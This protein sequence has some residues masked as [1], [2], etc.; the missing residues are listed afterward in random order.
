MAVL[1]AVFAGC[2][3]AADI[4]LVGVIGDKAAVLS[5]D[6]GAPKTIRVGRSFSGISVLAVEG[7]RAT[8]LIDGK[9][10][11]LVRGQHAASGGGVTSDRQRVTLVADARGHF[12]TD[13]A[14][15]GGSMRFLVDTGATAIAIPAADALRL[16]ID[17][18]KGGRVTIS[19]ANGQAQ[20]YLVKF[21]TVRVG[22]IE[23]AN[24][25]GMVVERGLSIALL[26]MSFLNR[27]EMQRDSH[28][29]TLIRRF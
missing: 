21:D 27:V 29:M 26:G 5:I 3:A 19:T 25:D 14:I 22:E 18:R 12:V 8:L 10:R 7:D 4:A 16:G 9:R 20:A 28:A 11:I 2:A 13:G 23:L 1:L 17:Y 24:V 15:N 6:G